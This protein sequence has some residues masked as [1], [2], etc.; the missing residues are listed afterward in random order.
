MLDPSIR[1]S[2]IRDLENLLDILNSTP[3]STVFQAFPLQ[4]LKI[5]QYPVGQRTHRMW[6]EADREEE[7]EDIECGEVLIVSND[8]EIGDDPAWVLYK[9]NP[10]RVSVG[11]IF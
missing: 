2:V 8:I 4:N 3:T 1:Q 6:F 7:E 9:G 11:C 10:V 5:E